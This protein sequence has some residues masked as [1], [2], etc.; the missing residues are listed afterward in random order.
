MEKPRNWPQDIKYLPAPSQS[1]SLSASHLAGIRARPAA[2]PFI[3]RDLCPCPNPWVKITAISSPKHPASGQYGLFATRHL[4]PGT[5]I[6]PY[7]GV[8]HPGTESS[9]ESD[10]DLSLDRDADLAVDAAQA[11]NEARFINDYR[12]VRDRPNAEF[13]EVWC[14]KYGQ[15]CMAVFVLPEGKKTKGKGGIAKGEEILVSYGKGFWG[16]RVGEQS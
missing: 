10:Y 14:E 5:L 4:K 9:T 15:R 7:I 8:V 11:G 3:P 16:H 2:L 12:G 1:K 13:R 6:L